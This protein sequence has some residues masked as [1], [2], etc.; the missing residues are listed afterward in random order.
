MVRG[1]LKCEWAILP[2]VIIEAA[3]LHV[4]VSTTMML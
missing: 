4:V 3:T 1:T 2:L